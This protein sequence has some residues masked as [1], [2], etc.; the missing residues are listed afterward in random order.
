MPKG[1]RRATVVLLAGCLALAGVSVVA[2]GAAAKKV[3]AVPYN[4]GIVTS[5]TGSSV[6]T[7]SVVEPTLDA[8]VKA[9]NASGGIKGGHKIKLYQATDADAASALTAVQNL[10][11]QH[12]IIALFDNSPEDYAFQ[13]Y[14]DSIKLPV[15][16]T[17]YNGK[18]FNT[19]P[20]FFSVSSPEANLGLNILTTIQKSGKTKVAVM[21][22]AEYAACNNTQALFG[23][24]LAQ[25]G[26]TLS[27]VAAISGSA[28]NYTAN[29]LAAQQAGATALVVFEP[30]AI[31][32]KV[33]DNCVAQGYSP[34]FVSTT[35]LAIPAWLSDP[36]MNG[37]EL[38]SPNVPDFVSSTPATK[39]EFA[40][41][42]KYDS[43]VLISANFSAE[44]PNTW[45]SGKALQLAM[46]NAKMGNKPSIAGMHK[47]FDTFKNE[48]FGGMAPPIT[49]KNG[50][51][52]LPSCV[53]TEYISG[54]KWKLNNGLKL[55]C[56]SA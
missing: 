9:V 11:T 42:A 48:T 18:L 21:Y 19:D 38:F 33:Y 24:Y 32:Q 51:T 23:P 20:N 45:V 56:P 13:T 15:V 53:F 8:W 54:G 26:T 6:A 29:C 10:V 4:I 50:Q 49:V 7:L 46:T 17:E 55:T 52:V 28:P 14:V 27:Y 39:A 3:K 44:V 35:S 37:A 30:G 1:A 31:G 36:S 25:T 43:G 12:H 16:G 5:T 22:C 40:A 2:A 34:L 41:L 47:G